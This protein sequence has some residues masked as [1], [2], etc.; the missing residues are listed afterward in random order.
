MSIHDTASRM[1]WDTKNAVSRYPAVAI[2]IARARGHGAVVDA[3]TDIVIEGYPRSANSFAVAAFDMPQPRPLRIAHH[4]HAA[5]QVIEGC[6]LGIPTLVL[7]RDPDDAVL[8]TCIYRPFL[9]VHDALWAYAWFYDAIWPYR[10]RYVVGPFP[11]VTTDFGRTMR[12]VNERYGSSF[13]PFT[14]HQEQV[15]RVF[16]AIDTY[17]K[18]QVGEGERFER[19]VGRPSS[20]RDRERERIRGSLDAPRLS[21]LRRH[22]ETRYRAL[23]T[24]AD[25]S[26]V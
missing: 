19:V 11:E 25:R 7:V 4:T 9:H 26:D 5:A 17:W 16:D 6:R 12:R 18:E 24:M 8:N 1:W 13:V 23:V 2:P 20:W 22:A 10:Y 15:V 3:R 21:G 14:H